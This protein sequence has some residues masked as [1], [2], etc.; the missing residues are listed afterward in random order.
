[1]AHH[2]LLI[3]IDRV[4][5]RPGRFAFFGK[6]RLWSAV[7]LCCFLLFLID[8]LVIV[9]AVVLR[10]EYPTTP[11]RGKGTGGTTEEPYPSKQGN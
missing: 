5:L 10:G 6:R 3:V 9:V 2:H 11:E 4:W 7:L 1:M 8:A